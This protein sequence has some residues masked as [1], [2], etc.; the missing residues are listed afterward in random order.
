MEPDKSKRISA[1]GETGLKVSDS[2]YPVAGSSI[3]AHILAGRIKSKTN[4]IL[5][6]NAIK[7][8]LQNMDLPPLKDGKMLNT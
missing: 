2:S 6:T 5:T 4:R 7:L 1:S 3:S 8:F